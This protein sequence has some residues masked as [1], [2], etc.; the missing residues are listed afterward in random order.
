LTT[1]VADASPLLYLAL[2][3]KLHLLQAEGHDIVIPGAVLEEVRGH[4][5]P[6]ARAIEEATKS[7]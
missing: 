1:W 4:D 3:E 5:D 6:A 2:L 7:W